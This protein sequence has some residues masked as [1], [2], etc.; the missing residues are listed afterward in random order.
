MRAR[1]STKKSYGELTYVF[2]F[3]M[4]IS[5]IQITILYSVCGVDSVYHPPAP[6]PPP[7]L[8]GENHRIP[9]SVSEELVT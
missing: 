8:R 5:F 3:S 6:P 2:F 9:F 1:L 4:Y 7:P